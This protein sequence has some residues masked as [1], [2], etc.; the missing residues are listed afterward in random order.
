MIRTLVSLAA[1][2]TIAGAADAQKAYVRDVPHSQINFIAESQ[3][4]DA[5]GTFD[6]WEA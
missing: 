1:L 3:L 6:R 2:V 5:H 4:V